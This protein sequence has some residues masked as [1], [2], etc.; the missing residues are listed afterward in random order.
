MLK[1][2][3]WND[4]K[5]EESLRKPE[6]NEEPVLEACEEEVPKEKKKGFSGKEKPFSQ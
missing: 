1:S 5:I 3:K 4:E 2:Y 6:E